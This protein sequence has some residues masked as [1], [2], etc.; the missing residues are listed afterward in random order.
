VE[1]PVV[2]VVSGGGGNVNSGSVPLVVV[3]VDSVEVAG[4]D[5]VVGVVVSAICSD[6]TRATSS[7]PL[8]AATKTTAARGNQ[9][10]L[11]G[12]SLP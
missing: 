8:H 7:D 4:G 11:T 2:G 10:R 5:S 6:D 12:A 1:P 9:R 3:G